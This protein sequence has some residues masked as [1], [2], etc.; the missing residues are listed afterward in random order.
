MR[1]QDPKSP[2]LLGGQF[3]GSGCVGE[4]LYCFQTPR[5]KKKIETLVLAPGLCVGTKWAFWGTGGGSRTPDP[6]R[7]EVGMRA[8]RERPASLEVVET[9]KG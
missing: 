7:H 2:F 6:A 8:A 5:F 3:W 1:G 4:V 9:V